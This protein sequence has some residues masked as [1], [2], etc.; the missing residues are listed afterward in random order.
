MLLPISLIPVSSIGHECAGGEGEGVQD[1]H[2]YDGFYTL[3]CSK[4]IG[5]SIVT[6]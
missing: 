6:S 2:S 3:H 5:R 4:F 1:L